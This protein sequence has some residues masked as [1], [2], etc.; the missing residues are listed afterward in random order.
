MFKPHSRWRRLLLRPRAL[1]RRYPPRGIFVPVT[2]GRLHA[3]R[4]HRPGTTHEPAAVLLHGASGNACDMGLELFDLVARQRQTLSFDRPGHGWSDRPGGA[5]DA[6][7]A[8]QGALIA[9]ALEHLRIRRTIVV[10]HSWSGG[11]ALAMALDRPDLVAGVV[12]IAAATHPWP[13]GEISWYNR[14]GAHQRFGRAFAALAPLGQLA[15]P[16]AVEAVFAP[17]EPPP[18]FADRT[19]LPL[20]FRPGQ[21]LANAQDMAGLHAFLTR[22]HERYGSLRRPVTTLVSEDDG[23]VPMAH[24]VALAEAS[25]LVELRVMR[26]LGHV[27]QHVAPQAAAKA[28]EDMAK[29]IERAEASSTVHAAE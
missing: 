20:L 25:P 2:G 3:L 28:V 1:E 4:R 24:G 12:L 10:A 18:G 16:M 7:P 6:N 19:A 23:I 11:L 14:F 15:L 13:G 5:S 8:R 9:E 21:F 17:Q 29:R 26:G 27:L 22:Q